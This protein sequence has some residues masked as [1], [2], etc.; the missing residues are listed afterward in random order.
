M[1]FAGWDRRIKTRPGTLRAPLERTDRSQ[2]TEQS[3][4]IPPF[5]VF[6]TFCKDSGFHS[7]PFAVRPQ[8]PP[9]QN[10]NPCSSVFIRGFLSSLCQTSSDL[11]RLKFPEV[12]TASPISDPAYCLT[13]AR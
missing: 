4:P 8:R 9:V 13:E 6:V 5:V 7:R 2:G 10:P 12:T 11:F 3:S 1:N